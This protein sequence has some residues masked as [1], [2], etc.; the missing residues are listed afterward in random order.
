MKQ[1]MADLRRA[2]IQLVRCDQQKEENENFVAND[3][4]ATNS[5]ERTDTHT[6]K[7]HP[8]AKDGLIP[9]VSAASPIPRLA[10]DRPSPRPP[11]QH[12]CLS[13]ETFQAFAK[14]VKR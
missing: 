6:F 14:T 10:V 13:K 1:E 12:H 5:N 2:D 7:V 9:N 11:S 3:V 4:D 8:G